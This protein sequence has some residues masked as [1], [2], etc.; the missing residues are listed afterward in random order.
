MARG[1]T[2]PWVDREEL[3]DPVAYGGHLAPSQC[4]SEMGP[5]GTGPF[6]VCLPATVHPGPLWASGVEHRGQEPRQFGRTPAWPGH[7]PMG[8]LG[9]Q[10][11]GPHRK[12]TESNVIRGTA[13]I[14]RLSLALL[15]M[16]QL[17]QEGRVG[18]GRKVEF[19]ARHSSL[20]EFCSQQTRASVPYSPVAGVRPATQQSQLTGA[21]WGRGS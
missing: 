1:P 6:P 9:L 19:S 3:F 7:G 10:A 15:P 20:P 12:N 8:G 17:S 14:P 16:L 21:G 5:Q 13:D 18:E 4:H 11:P 2:R